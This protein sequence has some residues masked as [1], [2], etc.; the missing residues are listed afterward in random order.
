MRFVAYY[1]VSTQRQGQSGLGLEAQQ[2]A[3]DSYLASQ[4]GA[5]LIAS[6]Q[7]VESG[8]NNNRPQLQ[9][10]IR[11]CGLTNATL[12][13]AKLDRLSR[14][15]AFLLTLQ[16]SGLDFV[17]VDM[18][19]A[20]R[21]TVSIM[22]CLAEEERR[23]ISARTKAALE[24]ARARGVHLGNPRGAKAFNGHDR[25]GAAAALKEKADKRAEQVGPMVSSMRASGMSLRAI[26]ASLNANGIK[27]ARGTIWYPTSVKNVIDRLSA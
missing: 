26:A 2:A 20:N 12:L 9:A 5:E 4:Q 25:E 17:A 14:D 11:Q 7:E 27:T 22:A 1:R 16:S 18:P 24:A 10:A 19:R 6:Y 13:V 3:V 8:K 15:A 23:M 21:F